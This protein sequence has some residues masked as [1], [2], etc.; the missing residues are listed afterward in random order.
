[1]TD[2]EILVAF[3]KAEATGYI[4]KFTKS[5]HYCQDEDCDDCP[6]KLACRQLV[7]DSKDCDF[8]TGYKYWAKR[9]PFLS[10]SELQQQ[11]PELLL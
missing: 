7:N 11:Y 6:A 2:L 1:M 8:Y 9:T 10:L 4:H 3:R 5:V